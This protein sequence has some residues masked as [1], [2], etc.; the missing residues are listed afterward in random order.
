MVDMKNLKDLPGKR[1]EIRE[2]LLLSCSLNNP[3]PE[4]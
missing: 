3:G 1:K 2:M 4:L